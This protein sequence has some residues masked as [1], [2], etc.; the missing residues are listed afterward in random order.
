MGGTTGLAEKLESS[1]KQKLFIAILSMT[2]SALT[3]ADIAYAAGVHAP[4][5][6]R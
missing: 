1:V 2:F 4:A 3:M 6:T 5:P